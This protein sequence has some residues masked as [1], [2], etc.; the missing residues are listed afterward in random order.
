LSL[1]QELCITAPVVIHNG[2]VIYD[3]LSGTTLS[4][5][6]I[7]LNTAQDIVDKLD[8]RGINYIVYTGESSGERVLA[9]SGSWN[10]SENLLSYYLGER[11]E[12]IEKVTLGAPPVRISVIDQTDRVNSFS[13]ELNRQHL[14]MF[15]ALTFGTEENIW[16]GIELLP[17]GCNKGVGL[18]AV[19][20]NLGF[21]AQEVIAIGDNINDLEMIAWAGL[22][23]AME[24]GSSQA[25]AKAKRIAPPH[26]ENGVAKIIKEFLL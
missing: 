8:R 9:L 2:A 20:E 16:R 7:D 3:P 11:A 26:D 24:N 18:A 6:G 5:Q 1:V 13:E 17:P 19:V 23:I 12:F 22:G 21:G 4:Q 14:G 10:E 15:T 25:K